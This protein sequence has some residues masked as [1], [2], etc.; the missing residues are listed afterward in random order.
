M[1]DNA[2]YKYT[3]FNTD[4]PVTNKHRNAVIKYLTAEYIVKL[5][6][7]SL[8]YW[9]SRGYRTKYG[10]IKL[11]FL[12]PHGFLTPIQSQPIHRFCEFWPIGVETAVVTRFTYGTEYMLSFP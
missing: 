2:L 6:E 3:C 11:L 9:S 10:V 12:V 7:K 1:T 8:K 4:G 5:T